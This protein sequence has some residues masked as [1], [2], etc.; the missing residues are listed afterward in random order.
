M[1]LQDLVEFI[2]HLAKKAKNA[3]DF[4]KL[5]DENEAE[6]PTALGDQLFNIVRTLDAPRGEKGKTWDDVVAAEN[7]E[8]LNFPAL[9]IK[10]TETRSDTRHKIEVKKEGELSD[11]ARELLERE[12]L[13][14][15][16]DRERG[17]RNDAP[18]DKPREH[19]RG[20]HERDRR[21]RERYDR[22]RYDRGDRR[23]SRDD[24]RNASSRRDR[25]SYSAER[26]PSAEL[27]GRIF[28]GR[29][30]KIMDFGAFVRFQTEAGCYTGLVHVSEI[31]PGKRRLMDVRDVLKEDMKVHVKVLGVNGEKV[32]LSMKTVDQETGLEDASHT[33][34]SIAGARVVDDGTLERRGQ[35]TNVSLDNYAYG[36]DGRKRRMMTDLERWEQQQLLNSGVL[37]K[38]ERLGMNMNAQEEVVEEEIEIEINEAC[39]TFLKGQTRRSGIE[40]SPIKIVSNPEGSLARAIA[41]SSTIAKERREAERAQEDSVIRAGRGNAN[42][43]SLAGRQGE[44]STAQFMREL[45]SANR[46]QRRGA[47]SRGRSE[48]NSGHGSKGGAVKSIQ[49]QRESLPIFSLRDDLLQAVKENDILIVVGET[50]SGKSTQIPQYLAETGY[51]SSNGEI[52]VIGCTQPRRVAAMSVA[53]RVAEEVGCRLG[54]EVGYAIRFEDCTTKDTMIKFMTDG[55]LLREVL[56]DPLL[57]KYSCIMLDEAHERTIATDVLFALLKVRYRSHKDECQL[58]LSLCMRVHEGMIGNMSPQECSAKRKDFKLIVTS[59]TL[60]SEKFSAYFNDSSIFSIP[61]RMYPVE[62]LH[63]KEQESDYIEASLITV[64]NIH[65]NEPAGDILLFLTGQEEIDVACRTLHER[66]KRLESM[67]PPPLIILPVYA[68]LPGEMQ[69]AIFEPTPPG[70]RKCV[71]ATNIAEASL[72]IDGIF[73]VIDPGFA[74]VKRYNPRTGMESLVVVPISQASAKQRAGRAGRTGPGKCYRL[75]TEDSY[76]SEML[77]TAVPEIQ[78]TNL[79]NVVILLKAMGINDFLNFDFMDKPPVETLIDALDNLYH[80]G[81]LDDEGLLTRLGRKMAEFPMDPNLAKMLLTSIDM[82][83]SDEI[84]TIVSMLSIQNIFY[85]PQDKQAEADRAKSR[86]TQPEGDHLTLLNVYNQWR[87]NKFSSLWCHENF[88][89]ARALLR[90]QDVRKQLISIMD[91]YNFKVASCGNDPEKVAKSVCAGFFHHSARRDPQEGYRTIVDQQNVY[92]HPSSA[93]YNR[94]PEYVVYHELVMTTKE[95]M[96]DLTTVKA[97]WLLELAPSMFK[98]CDGMSKAKL[99]QKIEP[100]HNKFEEKDAWRLS[101]RRG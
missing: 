44:N 42:A 37:T 58:C 92:I 59:A 7:D 29:V 96:R 100:L 12:K 89:Q 85:R 39:P 79:A 54:Q 74:K 28:P 65:L 2:I 95:Y 31:L 26:P 72:T 81:A 40:L 84:I 86:F 19:E 63:T 82:G 101:K 6:M 67:S 43:E 25:R 21:S 83:C 36:V 64:L 75:Y 18:R 16:E 88:L 60:E 9:S 33:A 93:L 45:Q 1:R 23:H 62:I 11:W 56:Q 32:S 13:G 41:T 90:A 97:Q 20:R 4:N 73:Y 55:M 68:A 53:K 14:G 70:C 47:E 87:K 22:E 38:D 98:K 24:R 8:R 76:R 78:R 48:A 91:R 15:A 80:L 61:G 52:R 17:R 71:I 46:M 77:P 34:T 57:E 66:M 30:T 49:E 99:G 69:S 3:S 35:L 27:N 10:N 51:N 50:G 5:L 94:S